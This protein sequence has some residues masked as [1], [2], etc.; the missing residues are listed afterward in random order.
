MQ[1]QQD[2]PIMHRAVEAAGKR[3]HFLQSPWDQHPKLSLSS[4]TISGC[5]L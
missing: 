5:P 1:L 3:I 4:I 2:K